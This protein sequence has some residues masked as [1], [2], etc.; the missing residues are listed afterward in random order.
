[1]AK[2]KKVLY[3]LSSLDHGGV[4]LSVYRMQ[5]SLDPSLYQCTFCVI[6]DRV[7]EFEKKLVQ[8]GITIIHQP[9]MDYMQS[10]KYYLEMF[11]SNRFDVVHCNLPFYSGIVMLAAYKSNVPVRIT[12]SHFSKRLIYEN[13]SKLKEFLSV[14]YRIVMRRLTGAYSTH[15]IGCSKEAGEF[16]S[17]KKYFKSKGLVLNNAVDTDKYNYREN[18]REA[19]RKTLNISDRIVLGH[20]GHL[21]YIKNQ[22]FLLDIFSQFHKSHGNSVLLLVGGGNDEA[23]LKSKAERLNLGK[24]VVFT[25][26]RDDIPQLLL[27][28]DCMVFPSLHEGFPLTLVEAQASKLPCVVS[29]SVTKSVKLNENFS[30]VSLDAPVSDWCAKIE[31]MLKMNRQTIDNS[32]LVNEFDIKVIGK[33][34]EKIYTCN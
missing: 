30:F 6:Q 14:F 24:F 4:D 18:E 22:S 33:E 5:Q 26:V 17:S 32:N 15:I 2:K 29:D 34:L 10:Y 19:V 13:D 31:E 7:G 23:M 21:N 16:V 20:I 8:Q 9:K 25:G 12:H 11:S 1:M 27:A 28:M 3:I